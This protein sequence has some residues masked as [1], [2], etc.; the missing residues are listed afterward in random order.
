MKLA[1]NKDIGFL[2]YYFEKQES[3]QQSAGLKLENRIFY[4]KTWFLP[5]KLQENAILTSVDF[6][7]WDK[8]KKILEKTKNFQKTRIYDFY[9]IIILENQKYFSAISRL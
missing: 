4:A 7:I 9:M 8:I 2:C 3:F 5:Q 1:K 6:F